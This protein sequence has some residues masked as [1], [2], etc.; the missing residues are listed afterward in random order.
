MAKKAIAFSK[1]SRSSLS[2]ATSRRG[3]RISSSWLV[4]G[5]DPQL[6]GDGAEATTPLRQSH[7]CPLELGRELPSVSRHSTPPPKA[8]SGAC[9]CPLIRAKINPSL[10]DL[11]GAVTESAAE[12][13]RLEMMT[14]TVNMAGQLPIL[15]G[16]GAGAG[17]MKRMASPMVG[18]MLLSTVL[19]LLVIPAI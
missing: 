9:R 6:P 17:V 1:I 11:Y 15:W 3:W 2:C 16:R 7:R 5:A 14:V 8:Y 18:L 13:V 4:S 10:G 19:T 12:R